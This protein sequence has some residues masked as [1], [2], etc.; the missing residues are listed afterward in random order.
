MTTANPAS[1]ESRWPQRLARAH[2]HFLWQGLVVAIV[3][4]L[5]LAALRRSSANA[6]YLSLVI[7]LAV[8]AACPVAT[9]ALDP[10][11]V[12]SAPRMR[13]VR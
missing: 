3:A 6:R 12:R 13:R 2:L 7:M 1:G 9:F 11:A 10:E 8:L 4:W 5:V